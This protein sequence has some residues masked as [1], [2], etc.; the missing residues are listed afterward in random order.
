MVL[1]DTSV[2]VDH[3]RHGLPLLEELLESGQVAV[4]PFIIGELACG[5]LTK[6]KEIL[7][8]LSVLPPVKTA[9]QAEALRLVE[10]HALYNAGIVWVDVHLLASALLT[11][12]PIWTRD[13]RLTA[14]ARM[15]KLAAKE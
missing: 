8:L 9:T 11:D 13:R 7:G 10:T 3:F 14:A 2:W 12:I 6:R 1:V 15:L 5:G 4:H